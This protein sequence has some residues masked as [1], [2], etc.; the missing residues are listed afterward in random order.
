MSLADDR[1]R[2]SCG[3]CARLPIRPRPNSPRGWDVVRPTWAMWNWVSSVSISLKFE[4]I[5]V[6]SAFRWRNW[7]RNGKRGSAP[8]D[9]SGTDHS[10]RCVACRL[11]FRPLRDRSTVAGA[12]HSRSRAFSKVFQVIGC[13][14]PTT[15]TPA[16]RHLPRVG[17]S[18]A[19]RSGALSEIQTCLHV[20]V[21]SME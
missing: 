17:D 4:T 5:A 8:L 19:R 9:V 11:T 20:F 21:A 16:P 12:T 1:R 14:P 18:L 13:L 15:K 3:N 7:W 10:R 2:P 6:R